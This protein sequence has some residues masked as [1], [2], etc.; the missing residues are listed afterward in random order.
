[1][2]NQNFQSLNTLFDE[3]FSLLQNKSQGQTPSLKLLFEEFLN[4]LMV[5]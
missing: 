4:Y 2:K 5:K 1:M 3:L